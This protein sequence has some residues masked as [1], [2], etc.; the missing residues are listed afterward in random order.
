MTLNNFVGTQIFVLGIALTCVGAHLYQDHLQ[1][2]RDEQML[3]QSEEA[4]ALAT[5]GR[6]ERLFHVSQTKLYFIPSVEVESKA[7]DRIE[8]LY[9]LQCQKG[10]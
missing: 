3:E 6:M 7:S 1:S 9:R 4:A 5:Q 8:K 10:Y 2:K